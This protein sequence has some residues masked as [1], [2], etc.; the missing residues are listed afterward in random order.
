MVFEAGP[1]RTCSLADQA[2]MSCEVTRDR[3]TSAGDEVPTSFTAAE[4]AA[5]QTPVPASR[6]PTAYVAEPAPTHFAARQI[7]TDSMAATAMTCSFPATETPTVSTA[8]VAAITP[9]STPAWTRFNTS[10]CYSRSPA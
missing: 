8:R 4:A 5:E 6:E 2:G 1:I 9:E 10:R 7:A 3:M